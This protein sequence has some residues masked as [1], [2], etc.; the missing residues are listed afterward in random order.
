VRRIEAPTNRVLA[1]TRTLVRGK[2]DLPD[3]HAVQLKYTLTALTQLSQPGQPPIT[4]QSA[5]GL[6]PILD[7][8]GSGAKLFDDLSAA[9]QMDP[10]AASEHQRLAR[11][12]RVGIG[13][14]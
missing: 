6:L 12:A 11:F 4:V 5:I 9:L 7:L 14:V 2:A 10:P 13:P 1:L 3:A 8:S